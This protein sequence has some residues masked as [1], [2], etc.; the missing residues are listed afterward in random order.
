LGKAEVIKEG[1]DVTLVTAGAM[2][3]VALAAAAETNANVEIIDLLT[4]WPW[5]RKAVQESVARTGRLVTLEE[6][7]AGS[8]WGANVVAE[9]A[10]SCFGT[11]LAPPHR[12]TFPDA[13]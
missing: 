2:V 9:I 8:G 4:L 10:G 3:K 12:I 11:L 6:A 7:P 1:S 5:D 13:P